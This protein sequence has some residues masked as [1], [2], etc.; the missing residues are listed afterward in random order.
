MVE[1]LSLRRRPHQRSPLQIP[2]TMALVGMH[3][4][5]LQ[6]AL[7]RRVQD[8]AKRPFHEQRF[9]VHRL[10]AFE[11]LGQIAVDQPV[12]PGAQRCEELQDVRPFVECLRNPPLKP[13]STV[14]IRSRR[15][16]TSAY[17]SAH[18]FI[19]FFFSRLKSAAIARRTVRYV[20]ASRFISIHAATSAR[21]TKYATAFRRGSGADMRSA[22]VLKAL[23]RGPPRTPPAPRRISSSIS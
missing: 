10:P 9:L 8:R 2:F 11:G 16:F 4:Q 3:L 5:L 1:G 15:A 18:A 13:A 12:E 20:S 17:Q 6:A 23:L 21:L 7:E 14:R 22:H 19:P